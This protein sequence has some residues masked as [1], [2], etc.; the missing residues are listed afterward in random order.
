VRS[1]QSNSLYLLSLEEVM[2]WWRVARWV[3]RAG[4]AGVEEGLEDSCHNLPQA[5]PRDT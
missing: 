2:T 1:L 3:V 4:I 5:I